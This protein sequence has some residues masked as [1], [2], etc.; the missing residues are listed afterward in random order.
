[1]NAVVDHLSSECVQLKPAVNSGSTAASAAAASVVAA[2][3]LLG[4]PVKPQQPAAALEPVVAPVLKW[5]GQRYKQW[6]SALQ[7]A[8]KTHHKKV[9][10]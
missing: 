5:K 8:R 4:Q 2:A 7:S 3:K 1:M 9:R 6:T 10:R